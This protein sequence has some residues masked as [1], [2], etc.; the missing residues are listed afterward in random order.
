VIAPQNMTDL[1]RY[2]VDQYLMRGGTLFVAAGNY[3]LSQDQFTGGIALSPVESGLQEMLEA[4]GVKVEPSL[5]MD[6]QNASI[7]IPVTRNVGGVIV[8]EIQG[9]NY[10]FFVDIRQDGMRRDHPILTNLTAVTLN[11]ASPLTLDED[12]EATTLLK[13]SSN[14]WTRTN[15]D[16]QPDLERYPE[17]GFPVEGEQHSY[18]LAALVEGSFDSFFK[19]KPSP[20][21]TPASEQGDQAGA[22]AETETASAGLIE[23]SPPSARLIVVGSSEFLNDTVSQFSLGLGRDTGLE[24]QQFIQNM[25]DWATEDT[26]LLAIRSR[27]TTRVL[28]PLSD[29]DETIWEVLNYAFALVSVV[30]IG[31]LWLVR[32]RTEKPMVLVPQDGAVNVTQELQES[33]S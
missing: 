15:L 8:Q 28:D 3:Q 21:E 16:I 23:S 12:R 13:S 17:L 24:A 20:F 31:L 29:R 2:A 9:L 11:W 32:K 22:D 14:T 30:V 6:T 19:D 1:D 26:D 18:P 5:V 4:Y 10:P 25:V 7:A 33:A 27:G